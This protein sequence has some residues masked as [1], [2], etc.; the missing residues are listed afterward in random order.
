MKHCNNHVYQYETSERNT[1]PLSEE[2]AQY[3]FE[4]EE[5][6]GQLGKMLLDR[7]LRTIL[8][9]ALHRTWETI[10]NLP[11]NDAEPYV[12]STLI[13]KQ[14]GRSLRVIEDD[15]KRFKDMNLLE[16]YSDLIDA[17]DGKSFAA[18]RKNFANLYKLAHEYLLWEQSQGFRMYPPDVRHADLVRANRELYKKLIRFEN[19]RRILENKKTGPKGKRNSEENTEVPNLWGK[20]K[21]NNELRDVSRKKL[22]LSATYESHSLIID[23][24]EDS[25][26]TQDKFIVTQDSPLTR[27][28]ACEY[29]HDER[30]PHEGFTMGSGKGSG[31]QYDFVVPNKPQQRMTSQRETE[32]SSQSNAPQ[33][34]KNTTA[35]QKSKA[36]IEA[37]LQEKDRK[38]NTPKQERC[39]RWLASEEL[40]KEC[41]SIVNLYSHIADRLND[42]NPKSTETLLS[43]IFQQS[44][45]SEEEFIVYVD[46][47]KQKVC[48]IPQDKIRKRGAD[49]KANRTPLFLQILK[50]ALKRGIEACIEDDRRA[51]EVRNM[52]KFMNQQPTTEIGQDSIDQVIEEILR[53]EIEASYQVQAEIMAKVEDSAGAEELVVEPMQE[54]Q[55]KIAKNQIMDIIPERAFV[56]ISQMQQCNCGCKIIVR[57]GAVVDCIACNPPNKWPKHVKEKIAK[58]VRDIA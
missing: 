6:E 45:M 22:V 15:I 46:Y 28:D 38:A 4:F 9:P 1:G 48:S 33:T 27:R 12:S 53:P 37:F 24:I 30:S 21:N 3:R 23:S 35:Q 20:A 58:I 19:Y 51:D 36:Y 14:A 41:R 2:K 11:H 29:P 52:T 50:D 25:N 55:W 16:T 54:D 10:F 17:K 31:E 40:R 44:G 32:P 57:Q 18:E 49:G 13:A 5:F 42:Q 47:A 39:N 34:A 56:I 26:L 7:I 43:K 8:P